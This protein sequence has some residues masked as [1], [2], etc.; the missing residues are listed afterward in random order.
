MG[1]KRG[2]KVVLAVRSAH[3]LESPLTDAAGAALTATAGH[4]RCL[5]DAANAK[6]AAN[7]ARH[8]RL[9]DRFLEELDRIGVKRPVAEDS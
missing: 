1:G 4:F 7:G 9:G 6:L 8:R 3:G 2:S 5:V